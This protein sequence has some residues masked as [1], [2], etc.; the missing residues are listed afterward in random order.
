[1]HGY[2]DLYVADGAIIPRP[3]A[4]NPSLTISALAE[5]VAYWMIHKGELVTGKPTPES[6]SAARS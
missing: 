3:L 5:R 4:V 1:M 2:P 6:G